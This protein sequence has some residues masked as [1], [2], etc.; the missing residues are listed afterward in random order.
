MSLHATEVGGSQMAPELA[1]DLVSRDDDETR[2]ILENV[3]FLMIR[4][5][6]LTGRSW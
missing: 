5:S 6:T 1:W 3:V 2:R 4:R